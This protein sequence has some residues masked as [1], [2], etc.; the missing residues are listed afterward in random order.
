MGSIGAS[1]HVKLSAP[2]KGPA[3]WRV[4]ILH[5]LDATTDIDSLIESL[6]EFTDF[7][8]VRAD[9]LNTITF[10]IHKDET[11]PSIINRIDQKNK[12]ILQQID[13]LLMVNTPAALAQAIR[14]SS[15]NTRTIS[16]ITT[17]ETGA[18]ATDPSEVDA[19]ICLEVT[20]NLAQ[21]GWRRKLEIS[22]LEKLPLAIMRVLRETGPKSLDMLFQ[23]S[24]EPLYDPD[25]L[26]FDPRKYQGLIRLDGTEI[27][28]ADT[29]RNYIQT[30]CGHIKS[31]Y[32]T[33]S[34]YMKYRSFCTEIENGGD[35]AQFIENC[36]KDGVL[37]DVH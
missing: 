23:I 29:M 3:G 36:L 11:L 24:G 13:H 9:R 32:I 35:P 12:E 30:L 17:E 19:L 8:P 16:V 5:H 37:F 27:T 28:P 18:L 7:S 6:G 4:C 31:L 25:L 20:P 33:E 15:A 26:E 10:D 22:S 1:G 14:Y 2:V 34:V 21:G